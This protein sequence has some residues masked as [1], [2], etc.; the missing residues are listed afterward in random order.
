MSKTLGITILDANEPNS[1]WE[2]NK[3]SP[4]FKELIDN[5]SQQD[6]PNTTPIVYCY[7]GGGKKYPAI[8]ERLNN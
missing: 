6:F 4:L 8:L 5:Q 3:F 2:K 1:H 7:E